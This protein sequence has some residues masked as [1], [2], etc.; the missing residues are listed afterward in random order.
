MRLEAG[1]DWLE[2]C[3]DMVHG[4]DQYTLSLDVEVEA[5]DGAPGGGAGGRE[6]GTGAE[7]E[8]EAAVEACMPQLR[9]RILSDC[10]L[11]VLDSDGGG[12]GHSATYEWRAPAN[13]VE[14][15]FERTLLRQAE[16]RPEVLLQ[17]GERPSAAEMAATASHVLQE[18]LRRAMALAAAAGTREV[19]GGMANAVLDEVEREFGLRPRS[20]PPP[21]P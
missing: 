21:P 11:E 17:A 20:R 4:E 12:G 15:V 2:A 18:V 13:S 3:V 16:V 7:G 9:V 5:E 8:A 10:A 1:G 19:T 14:Q 6:A